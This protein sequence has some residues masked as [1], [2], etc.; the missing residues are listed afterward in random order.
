M[1]KIFKKK[2]SVLVP[3]LVPGCTWGNGVFRKSTLFDIFSEGI[4]CQ[5]KHKIMTTVQE[6]MIEERTSNKTSNATNTNSSFKFEF[7]R[8]S[9]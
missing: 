6:D 4:L 3:G 9:V 8:R 7:R 2:P 5:T 1:I